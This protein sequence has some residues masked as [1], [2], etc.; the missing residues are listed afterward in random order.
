M[1]E[2]ARERA[3]VDAEGPTDPIL[4]QLYNAKLEEYSLR[5]PDDHLFAAM[6]PIDEVISNA[7]MFNRCHSLRIAVE[8]VFESGS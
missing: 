2:D 1:W 6:E 3:E 4:I 5:F 7:R 8:S